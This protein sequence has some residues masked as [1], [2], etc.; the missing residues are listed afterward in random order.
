MTGAGLSLL[1][2]TRK[3]KADFQILSGQ[4]KFGKITTE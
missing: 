2:H 1:L 3:A 4:G